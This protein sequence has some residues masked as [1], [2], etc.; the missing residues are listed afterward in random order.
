MKEGK[1][2]CLEFLKSSVKDCWIGQGVAEKETEIED[3]YPQFLVKSH[4]V[5]LS[6]NE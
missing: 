4:Q 1:F 5:T 6:M 2:A 3:D